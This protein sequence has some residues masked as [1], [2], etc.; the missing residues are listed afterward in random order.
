MHSGIIELFRSLAALL[1]GGVIGV[2]FGIVQD[3]AYRRNQQRQQAGTLNSGWAV[4]PGSMRRVAGL[5]VTL[6]LVQLFCP[7]LFSDGVQW[8]VS[9]GLL[10]GYGAMLFRQ[11]RLRR[12]QG[13]L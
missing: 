12:A 3:Y 1:A 10:A 6:L 11:F 4:M 8:W 9:G 5:M 2:G 7:L 13:L